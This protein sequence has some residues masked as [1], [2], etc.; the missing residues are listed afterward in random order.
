MILGGGI[1][2]GNQVILAGGPGAG[3]TLFC[4][5]FLYKNAQQGLDSAMI[6]F[7]ETKEEII[8]NSKEAF[9]DFIELDQLINSGTLRIYDIKD[10][11]SIQKGVY[12]DRKD[13]VV[14]QSAAMREGAI[15]RFLGDGLEQNLNNLLKEAKIPF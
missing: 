10:L 9:P 6:S 3:K 1:P 14:G 7:E 2:E 5:A 4:M 11:M 8:R 12:A 13:G 15:N